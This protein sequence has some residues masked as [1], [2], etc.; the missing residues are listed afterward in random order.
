MGIAAD[1]ELPNKPQQEE[2]WSFRRLFP[3]SGVVNSFTKSFSNPFDVLLGYL[4]LILGI[5]EIIGRKVSWMMWVFAVLILLADLLERHKME[6]SE[7]KKK[8]KK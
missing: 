3:L 7:P 4:V 1:H 2:K 6:L 5:A 8:D